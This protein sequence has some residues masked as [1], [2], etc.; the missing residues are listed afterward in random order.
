MDEVTAAGFAAVAVMVAVMAA[1][2]RRVVAQRRR[3]AVVAQLVAPLALDEARVE[4]ILAM[5]ESRLEA[6]P[7][8]QEA[9]RIV[10]LERARIGQAGL[11]HQRRREE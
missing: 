1:R 8:V 7:V 11:P 6:W 10:A 4:E 9:A 3:S 2:L 5:P